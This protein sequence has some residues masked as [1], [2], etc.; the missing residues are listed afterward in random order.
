[1]NKH[2]ERCDETVSRKCWAQHLRTQMHLRNDPGN[3]ITPERRGRPAVV[4]PDNKTC[5]R[6]DVTVSRKGWTQHLRTQMH[7]RNDPYNTI[8]PGRRGRPKT[9]KLHR[10]VRFHSSIFQQPNVRTVVR[11]THTAYRSRLQTLEISN[12]KNF[13]DVREFLNNIERPVIG[14]IRRELARKSG[15]KVNVVV[16]AEYVK[17]EQRAQ[18]NFRAN[19]KTITP[20]TNFAEL[21]NKMETFEIRGS[22]WVLSRILKLELCINRYNPLRGRSYMP[23]PPALANK[24]AIINVKNR[25]NKC[26]LWSV[27]AALHPARKDAQRVSKYRQ[28][29]HE[30]HEALEGIEFPVKLTDVSK[31]A[32]RTNMSINVYTFDQKRVVPLEITK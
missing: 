24:K 11:R 27:L 2:C 29:E 30:F 14:N 12:S 13:L 10:E 22:Q 8:T 9:G 4:R 16:S 6:C 15:L 7:L 3:T 5:E 26:F 18:I 31:F 1:M 21:W 20:A 28:W 17:G 23:L 32:K 25:D 19:N